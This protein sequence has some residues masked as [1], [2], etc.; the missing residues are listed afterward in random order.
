[1]L[2][3]RRIALADDTCSS[4]HFRIRVEA[5]EG[6][7][8]AFMLYDMGSRN[9]SYVRLKVERELSHGDYVFIGRKLL[10]VEITAA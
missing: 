1:M 8:P 2:G 6:Q 7:E 5:R 9:G 10:R 3:D 4:Q